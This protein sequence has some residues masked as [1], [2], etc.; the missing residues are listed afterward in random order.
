MSHSTSGG[1]NAVFVVR[2]RSMSPRQITGSSDLSSYKG[3][4][5]HGGGKRNL[6]TPSPE[7]A[8]DPFR[9]TLPLP[10]PGATNHDAIHLRY[11][12][13]GQLAGEAP[14]RA[15]YSAI[16]RVA[17]KGT[18]PDRCLAAQERLHVVG[19]SRCGPTCIASG[20]TRSLRRSRW[21]SAHT[22]RRVAIDRP[23]SRPVPPGLR[24]RLR[25]YRYPGPLRRGLSP[26]LAPKMGR[27]L[28]WQPMHPT[29]LRPPPHRG[30]G[31]H[32]RISRH[33]GGG[34]YFCR[35]LRSA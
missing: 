7:K 15:F 1:P 5:Y 6:L 11:P 35:A 22:S 4:R 16:G 21:I 32:P 29:E 9:V 3:V 23:Q 17:A 30:D 10:V 25:Q 18:A 13:A 31:R 28:G 12:G 2:F 8:A 20:T 34:A 27:G 14:S 19:S 26:V 24:E 33:V